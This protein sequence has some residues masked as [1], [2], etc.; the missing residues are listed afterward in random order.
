MAC[1]MGMVAAVDALVMSLAAIG[2]MS[3]IH[4]MLTLL[5]LLPM[6]FLA[7]STRILSGKLHQQICHRAGAV[8][9]ADR[10]LPLDPYL[11]RAY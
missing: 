11:H 6:P 4:P 3:A 2:F 5:A 1:G 10:I 7:I 8:F 9:S